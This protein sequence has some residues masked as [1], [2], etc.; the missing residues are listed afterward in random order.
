MLIDRAGGVPETKVHAWPA[1]QRPFVGTFHEFGKQWGAPDGDREDSQF[2]GTT[3]PAT[4][5]ELAMDL[6][7]ERCYDSIIVD[8][9][10]DSEKEKLYV[11]MSRATDQLIVVGDPAVVRAVGGPDVAARLGT[12][13]RD[14]GEHGDQMVTRHCFFS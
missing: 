13:S 9:A 2:W 10:Q 8:E 12:Y 14:R 3:L 7:D 1:W 4:M 11:G 5:A 6:T